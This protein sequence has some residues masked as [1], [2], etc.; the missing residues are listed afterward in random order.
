MF[1]IS[2]PSYSHTSVPSS[3]RTMRGRDVA[4]LLGQVRFEHVGR[5]DDVVVDAHENK[6]VD[7]HAPLWRLKCTD[8]TVSTNLTLVS[9]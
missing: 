2:L 8:M 1:T 3:R 6:V 5:L 9:G 7:L 4:P